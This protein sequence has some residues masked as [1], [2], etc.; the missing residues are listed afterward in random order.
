MTLRNR[1]GRLDT[2]KMYVDPGFVE[3]ARWVLG[4]Q[5]MGAL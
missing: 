3:G 5:G 1:I 4:V 2:S